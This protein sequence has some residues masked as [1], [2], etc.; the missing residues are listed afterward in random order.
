MQAAALMKVI[1]QAPDCACDS[2]VI[3]STEE[4]EGVVMS[5]VYS[6]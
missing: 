1:S 5:N 2:L 3:S 6:L 4:S